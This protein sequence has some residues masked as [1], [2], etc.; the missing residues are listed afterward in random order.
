MQ[1]PQQ[2]WGACIAAVYES[3]SS[4]G[5]RFYFYFLF[6]GCPSVQN[7]SIDDLVSSSVTDILL[8]RHQSTAALTINQ[9]DEETLHDQK[10]DKDTDKDIGSD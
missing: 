8:W 9:K 2:T 4:G 6:F 10:E 1:R 5:L 7:S 3:A